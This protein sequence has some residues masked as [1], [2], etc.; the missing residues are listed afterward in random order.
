MNEPVLVG[1]DIGGTK[2]AVLIASRDHRVLS[3]Y[4][5]A[6]RTTSPEQF[7]SG[8]VAVVEQALQ[9]AG[10]SP[11]QIQA[12]GAGIPG[13]VDA[14]T[15]FVYTAVNL[16]LDAYPVGPELAS[17]FGVPV[18][19]ENDVRAA[20][21][22]AYDWLSAE[23]TVRQMAFISIGTGISAAVVIDGHL[24]SGATAKAIEIGHVPFETDGPL[25]ACGMRGCLEALASGPGIARQ[26]HERAPSLVHEDAG[27]KEVY[28]L[29]ARGQPDAAAV[30][31]Y[32]SQLLARAA[33]MLVSML[34]VEIVVFGGGVSAAGHGFIEPIIGALAELRRQSTLASRMIREDMIVALPPGHSAATWGA[35][36]LAQQLH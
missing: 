7:I 28:E 24:Y 34:D 15:G 14:G 20:A 12:I 30:V 19:L 29:A 9:R 10:C 36:A 3:R 26:L 4:V 32:T 22:G 2:T 23:R 5:A 21:L 18:A 35:I 31:T 16:N 17:A 33:Y 6:T 27:A 8:L 11:D 13:W 1:L 25:C